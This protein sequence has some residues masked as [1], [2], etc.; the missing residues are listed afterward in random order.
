[1]KRI[2]TFIS[3]VA[4]IFA[5]CIS[6]SANTTRV[7]DDAGLLDSSEESALENILGDIYNDFYFDAVVVTVDGVG[8]SS[9]TEY[10]DAF[11][12]YNGF[13]LNGIIIVVDM[14]WRE[15]W[16]STSGR[17]IDYFSDYALDYIGEEV[18]YYLSDGWYYKAF[19][20]FA[21]LS[22]DYIDYGINGNGEPDDFDFKYINGSE[23]VYESETGWGTTLLISVI[24]GFV[25]ALIC[26]SNMK[27]KLTTVGLQKS[28]EN[29]AI[30]NS[31][32][33]AS[34]GDNFLY[35]NISRSPRVKSSSS[36]GGSSHR[37]SSGRSHG[38]RGGRF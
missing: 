5:F 36:H 34:M 6:S 8:D 13:S 3:A 27:S 19:D 29:Y 24:A 18:V 32:N 7:Y 38:G 30:S 2:I 31:L 37:G 28:A 4:L 21:K 15:W 25:I 20:T 22:Y 16:I 11:Y 9:I 12:D 14:E 35:K 17:A 33:I 1:M 26:T 10:A 23:Y